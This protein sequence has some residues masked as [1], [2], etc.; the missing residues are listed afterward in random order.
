MYIQQ[1]GSVALSSFQWCQL[2]NRKENLRTRFQLMGE[3][4]GDLIMKDLNA[5]L[6]ENM[7]MLKEE[8]IERW[9]SEHLQKK[10]SLHFYY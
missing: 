10:S 9:D 5:P 3:Y 1:S 6:P 8:D 7:R 2:K 4:Q